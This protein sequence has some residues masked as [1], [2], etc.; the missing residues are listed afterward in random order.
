MKYRPEIDGLRALAV[1]SVVVFHFFPIHFELG[2]L[3]VDVFFVI[4]GYLITRHLLESEKQSFLNFLKV[5]YTKRIKRLFPAFFVFLFI[6]TIFVNFLFLKPDLEKYFQSLVA[7]Q[8]FWA[9]IFFWLDGGYFGGND[10]LKPLLHIWSLSVE[11]QF[12]IAYPSFL[13]F[14]LYAVTKFNRLVFWGISTAILVSLCLWLYLNKIGGSNPAFFLLPTRAWQFGFGAI[15]ALMHHNKIG[16]EISFSQATSPISLVL[17]SVGFLI[18]ASQVMNTFLV[19]SGAALFIFGLRQ[20]RNFVF[21]L[22]SSLPFTSMGTISYS[23]YLYHWPIAVFLLYALVDKPSPFLSLI[24]VIL[25]VIFGSLS[26]KLVEIPFRYGRP[27]RNTAFLIST[28]SVLATTGTLTALHLTGDK[29]TTLLAKNSGTNY[30]CSIT[31]YVTYGASRACKIGERRGVQEVVLLG[32][33]HAQMYAPLVDRILLGKNRGGYLVPLNGCLPTVIANISKT[34]LQMALKNFES[35]AS[36]SNIKLVI[37]ASTWYSDSY[38]DEDGK[39]YESASLAFAFLDLI[40][41][42]K[43]SGKHVALISPIQIPV[44][45]LASNL[46]RLLK[47]RHISHKDVEES[48]KYPRVEY[49]ERFGDLNSIF[50]EKLNASYIETYLD[51]CDDSYCYFGRDSEIYFADGNH[52]SENILEELKLTKNKL[53]STIEKS[54]Y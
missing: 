52:L 45:D 27:F 6:V 13:F 51:L 50:K 7:S 46:P 34:C 10:Q 44:E 20:E 43:V 53:T 39:Q 3:G 30:R 21:R 23:V 1:T 18:P 4:S 28:L 8:T 15:F 31:Q 42:L 36:D 33:S 19:T 26:Y 41:K 9:N 37:V 17:L 22:F 24:G 48:L 11:E 5:F 16:A 2:Y 38:V 49:N 47:F 35:I 12:Y 32:N 14:L 25:S 40:E 29:A 54:F